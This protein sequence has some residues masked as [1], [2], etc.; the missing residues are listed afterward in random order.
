MPEQARA[1]VQR[2]FG[3][4]ALKPQQEEVLAHIWAGRDTVAVLPTG[5]GKTLCYAVPALLRDGLVLVVSPLIALIRDQ[6]ERLTRDGVA[7]V[8][9]DSHQTMDEKD[10]VWRRLADGQIKLLF[11]SPE[12]LARPAFRQRLHALPVQL[13][14]IDEAHC[15]SHI[16][17]HFRPDYRFL[18]EYLDDIRADGSPVQRLALTATATAKVRE[19]IAAALHLREPATVWTD[20]AR[21]NLKLKVIKAAKIPEQMTFI[22][23]AVLQTDGPGIVYT[24]T[25]KQT[26]EIQ[27]ML[28]NAGVKAVAYHAGL[29][30][31]E[32]AQNQRAFMRDEVRVVVAT[33][34]FGM[35]ID[36]ANIRFVHH[37]GLPASLEHYVQ[38]I[39]RAGRDGQP[40]SC[41]L[42]YASRDYHI[43]KFM[44]EKS[45]PD[46]VRLQA[47][48]AAARAYLS[49]MALQSEEALLRR[50]EQVLDLSVDDIRDALAVL[51]REGLLTPL[52]SG[53]AAGGDPRLGDTEPW[54]E[55]LISAESNTDSDAFF[56]QY[57]L[58][59]LDVL[60]KLE[61]M[62]AFA[63]L[64]AGQ[65]EFLND[66][67]RR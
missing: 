14:A 43:Q 22:L 53:A 21:P 5:S 36:K 52:R 3:F 58:R 27:R 8:A 44:L 54:P 26:H 7:C 15:I 40:A 2:L 18:G 66:Y 29:S 23:Q 50:L 1:L 38:E 34:A 63:A 24:T 61:S 60:A 13:V 25:R 48:C 16:G 19:E 67:F 41:W 9:L 42:V 59:K 31:F 56:R 39:G 49:D 12:R 46:P 17:Q 4:K 30:A 6:V 28:E 33:H 55:I 62:R 11:V 35:G 65:V 64:P 47:V 51:Y 32:R 45:L 20:F 37:A 10:E 57:P